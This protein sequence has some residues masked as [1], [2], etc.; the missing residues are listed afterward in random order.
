[1]WP[2]GAPF[3]L[4]LFSVPMQAQFR[5]QKY[6]FGYGTVFL[7]DAKPLLQNAEGP[8]ARWLDSHLMTANLSPIPPIFS[9]A[10]P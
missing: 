8:H 1:M 9:E 3:R 6:S 7:W 4:D 10:L 5:R 2:V